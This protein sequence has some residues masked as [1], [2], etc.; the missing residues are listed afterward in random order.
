M[1]LV[2][3]KMRVKVWDDENQLFVPVDS[4]AELRTTKV[5]ESSTQSIHEQSGYQ[6]RIGQAFQVSKPPFSKTSP[7][8]ESPFPLNVEQSVN[9]LSV[10]ILMSPPPQQSMVMISPPTIRRFH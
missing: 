8:A 7:S 2:C 6:S 3:L 1:D 10:E 4:K 9:I 5:D